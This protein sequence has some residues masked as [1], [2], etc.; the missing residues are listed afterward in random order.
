MAG[1]R[2]RHGL[3]VKLPAL[4]KVRL[5]AGIEMLHLSCVVEGGLGE[6]W[7]HPWVEWYE[8][9]MWSFSFL[10]LPWAV[11]PLFLHLKGGL[12]SNAITENPC[13]TACLPSS[14][15]CSW[16]PDSTA[17]G[18]LMAAVVEE[19]EEEEEGSAFSIPFRVPGAILPL[20]TPA[21][22]AAEAWT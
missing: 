13:I 16:L 9:N 11:L 19:E 18:W 15:W 7:P 10:R 12:L 4:I 20:D 21:R 3:D 8:V 5:S 1:R 22:L 2:Y 6:P 14:S 17:L